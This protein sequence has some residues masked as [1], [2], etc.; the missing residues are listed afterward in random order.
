MT[1]LSKEDL[2]FWEENGYVIIPNAAPPALIQEVENAV[3]DFLEMDADSPDSWYPDPPRGSIM[4][5]IYQHPA[6]WGTRQYPRVHQAFA[7]IW[8]TEK[9]WVSF[10]RAQ[11]ESS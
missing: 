6:L 7:E 4:V 1:V 9:L 5:E 8:G 10:D 11:H 2:A 3:W